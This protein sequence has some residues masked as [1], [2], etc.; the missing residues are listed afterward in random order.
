MLVPAPPRAGGGG[1]V[2]RCELASRVL[3]YGGQGVRTSGV[4]RSEQRAGADSDALEC[5]GRAASGGGG[6]SA[7]SAQLASRAQPAAAAS[8]PASAGSSARPPNTHPHRRPGSPR[9]RPSLLTRAAPS[10]VKGPQNQLTVHLYIHLGPL[11]T[12]SSALCSPALLPVRSLV[13]RTPRSSAPAPVNR[14]TRSTAAVV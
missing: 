14:G 2:E 8:A 11:D 4:D 1:W 12:R 7:L 6:G 3:A 5:G 13:L 9:T 10:T